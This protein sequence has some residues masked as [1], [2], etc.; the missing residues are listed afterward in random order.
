MLARF[1]GSNRQNDSYAKRTPTIISQ[2]AI[3]QIDCRD[4]SNKRHIRFSSPTNPLKIPH[5][6]FTSIV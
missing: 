1:C 6:A 4:I 2:K 3:D 5:L